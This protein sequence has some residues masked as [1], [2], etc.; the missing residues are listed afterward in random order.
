MY[1]VDP[2][3]WKHSKYTINQKV[4]KLYKKLEKIYRKYIICINWSIK[5]ENNNL[6]I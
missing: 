6:I 2:F 1:K 3:T 4:Q 5:K